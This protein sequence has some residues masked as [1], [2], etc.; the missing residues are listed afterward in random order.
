V[1]SKASA[2]VP[3]TVTARPGMCA[4]QVSCTQIPKSAPRDISRGTYLMHKCILGPSS[5]DQHRPV[6]LH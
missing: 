6:L 4:A 1:L 3:E 5:Q 2:S